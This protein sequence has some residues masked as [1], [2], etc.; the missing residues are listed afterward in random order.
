M[1]GVL[2]ARSASEVRPSLALR[3]GKESGNRRASGQ[4]GGD[5]CQEGL[6]RLG[7]YRREQRPWLPHLTVVR[8]RRRPR[9][10]PPVPDLGPFGPSDAAL[11]NSL[12]RSAGAQ[13]VV[14]DNATLGTNVA[15]GGN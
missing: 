10:Q 2:P 3:A 6:Q 9:L 5:L 4:P 15:L 1:S 8:F 7:V 11:Y 13:Y 12:L 14:I